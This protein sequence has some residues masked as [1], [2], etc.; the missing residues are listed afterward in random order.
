MCLSSSSIMWGKQSLWDVCPPLPADL[1]WSCAPWGLWRELALHRRLCVW[2]WLHAESWWVCTS[3][4][5]WLSVRR[6]VLSKQTGTVSCCTHC[7]YN[8]SL[9]Y[10]CCLLF[11]HFSLLVLLILC[12]L[13]FSQ[14]FYPEESCKTRCVCSDSGE[15]ECDPKFQCSVNEKCAVKDGLAACYPKGVGSCSVSGVRT[16]RSFDGKVIFS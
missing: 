7:C 6:T 13:L 2:R 16:V 10:W 15:V 11:C 12:S 9:F 1:Q 8:S 3:G 14:V 4:R 5:V